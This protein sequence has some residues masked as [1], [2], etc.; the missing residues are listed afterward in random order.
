MLQAQITLKAVNKLS[1]NVV[2]I[3]FVVGTERKTGNQIWQRI[4]G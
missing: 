4:E 1:K 2:K 3:E